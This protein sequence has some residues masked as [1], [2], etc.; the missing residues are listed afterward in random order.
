MARATCWLCSLDGRRYLGGACV[1]VWLCM[2]VSVCVCV[3]VGVCVCACVRACVCVC[4]FIYIYIYV[5]VCVCVSVYLSACLLVCLSACLSAYVSVCLCVC[6]CV[7]WT[8]VFWGQNQTPWPGDGKHTVQGSGPRRRDRMGMP[9]RKEPLT[10]AS[11]G[12][13]IH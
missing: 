6:L 1:C 8:W 3:C 12:F 13:K 9:L 5:Y 2:W 7:C 4:V 11:K 10:R